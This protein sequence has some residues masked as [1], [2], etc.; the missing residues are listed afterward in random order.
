MSF[1]LPTLLLTYVEVPLLIE[2]G[3]FHSQ[4]VNPYES[5]RLLTFLFI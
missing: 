5:L 3:Y 1:F 2:Y 4:N